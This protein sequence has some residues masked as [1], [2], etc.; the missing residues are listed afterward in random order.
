MTPPGDIEL[1]QAER[2]ASAGCPAALSRYTRRLPHCWHAA[3]HADAA[4]H[5]AQCCLCLV[6]STP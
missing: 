1:K 6:E 4:A 2:E 5:R 3:T